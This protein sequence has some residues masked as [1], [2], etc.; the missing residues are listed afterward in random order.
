[1]SFLNSTNGGYIVGGVGLLTVAAIGYM[2]Y[3]T[4]DTLKQAAKYPR[5]TFNAFT[6]NIS[7][8]K[9]QGSSS[10]SDAI[11]EASS[12]ASDLFSSSGSSRGGGTKR[13]KKGC[14]RKTKGQN[15]R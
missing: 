5:S 9:V 15:K 2:A 14:K 7:S 4:S 11:S 13:N 3:D 6:K 1:M 8:A 10:V 12:K